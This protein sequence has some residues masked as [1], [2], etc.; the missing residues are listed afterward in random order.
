MQVLLTPALAW[1]IVTCMK[2]PAHLL[3]ASLMLI[4]LACIAVN[5]L[6]F[7]QPRLTQAPT[8][9]PTNPAP[10]PTQT[11][12]PTPTPAPTLTPIPTQRIASGEAAVFNGDWEA[13]L[14]QYQ[15]ALQAGQD[16]ELQAAALL[17][18]A[19][20]RL[21]AGEHEAAIADLELL[22]SQFPAASQIPAAYFHLGRAYSDVGRHAESAAAYKNYLAL[23]PG[24]IDQYTLD[25]YGDELAA[26]GQLAE[27]LIAYRSALQAAGML[28]P[29]QIQMK[30]ARSHAA[31]ADY[32]TALGVYQVIFNQTQS[33]YTKA[34][35]DLLSGQIY[36][37]I[38]QPEQ[39]Y[40]AYLDAVNNF[41][42]SYD[43]YLALIALVEAG[44]PVNELNRGIV[45]YYAGQY[46]V[47]RA[48]FE[49]Y[50]QSNEPDQATAHYYNGLT[51]RALGLHQAALAEWDTVIQNYPEDSIWDRAWEQKALTLWSYMNDYGAAIQT[52]FNFVSSVPAHPRAGEF[53]FEAARI[54]ERDDQLQTAAEL[55]VRMA[56]DYPN[57]EQAQRALFLAGIM[58][59]RMQDYPGALAIFQRFLENALSLQDRTAALF[60][61]GK[62][63]QA[64]GDQPAS[65]ASWELAANLDP[66][67][68]YSERA[69]DLLRQRQPFSNPLQFDLSMDLRA[70]KEQADA[71][72]RST[73]ALPESADLSSPGLLGADPRLRRGYEL[74][75][76][77]L[78]EAA[79]AE[80]EDL[81]KSVQADPLANYQLAVFLSE[82][83][84]YRSAILAAR[85]VLDLAGMSDAETM[86]APPF[87][88]HIRFG[89]YFA[90]IVIPAARQ[91]N[92]HPLF[93]YSVIRQESAFE[94]FVRSSAGARGL[95][96]IIPATGEEVASRLGW[97][98]GFTAEDLYRPIVSLTLGADYL[99]TWQ[100]YF[101]GDLY[102]ALAAYNGGP[103]NAIAWK[104]LA[105]TDP[106]LF[107]EVIRFEETRN[108]LRGIYEIFSIYRRL[109][110]RES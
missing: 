13:A 4:S 93:L 9:E 57:D 79:R 78:Y 110:T 63:Q 107:L 90:E 55:W 72:M 52:L 59:Y 11:P 92:L 34:Q 14:A 27:A 104:K 74:W 86:N 101:D 24:L 35:V 94:G 20:T 28:D 33:D 30:I 17:G 102:A 40:A 36:M 108:Y 10:T 6:P 1:V 75:Q 84:L 56:V 81:R 73:F 7:M 15:A 29:L 2:K 3:L 69:R 38:G 37:A 43:S 80:F 91:N 87:F 66:T 76:L 22:L 88:N 89:T 18:Q 67:G 61:Q 54:A 50:F 21:L 16:A 19:K 5:N 103:G 97:P 60:W 65:A 51:L 48:A 95:M 109:Y 64:L 82:L 105:P 70:E 83:G 25:L 32:E 68:Y 26:T 41:P 42:T 44:I 12:S 106:D 49:R 77:G 62:S 96:Q 99:A 71:W 47:A 46:G 85:Q 23:R 45:D 58:H 39:A 98:D 53:L 8:A 100:D 31:L